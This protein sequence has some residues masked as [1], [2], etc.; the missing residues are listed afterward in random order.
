MPKF[1]QTNYNFFKTEQ[2]YTKNLT[3]CM[4]VKKITT[5]ILFAVY[6]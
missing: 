3:K 4:Y 1:Q 5:N 2:I 6:L